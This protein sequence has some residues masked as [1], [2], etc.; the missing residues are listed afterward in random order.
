VLHLDSFSG[1]GE[2]DMSL[3]NIAR[4][5]I[6]LLSL[7]DSSSEVNVTVGPILIPEG[8]TTINLSELFDLDNHA[9]QWVANLTNYDNYTL[10]L[11]N[12]LCLEAIEP[13]KVSVKIYPD[14][15]IFVEAK[16]KQSCMLSFRLASDDPR[17]LSLDFM[18]RPLRRKIIHT[19]NATLDV[20]F[21]YESNIILFGSKT[22]TVNLDSWQMCILEVE[23]VLLE[24]GTILLG[25]FVDGEITGSKT[26]TIR[27]YR[28]LSDAKSQTNSIA[29]FQL[30]DLQRWLL[31]KGTIKDVSTLYLRID[32]LNVVGNFTL[33]VQVYSFGLYY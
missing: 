13:E 1:K 5:E 32:N 21:S 22:L 19:I 29:E 20:S 3:K 31:F 24:N 27:V 26:A 12:F 33:W 8:L 4:I 28:T 2:N 10:L 11:P 9:S 17:A 7:I 15:I 30:A 25:A 6:D 14:S 23:D 18:S 16:C